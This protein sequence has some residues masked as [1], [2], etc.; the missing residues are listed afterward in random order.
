MSYA[1]KEYAGLM[2]T[3]GFSDALLK[4]HFTLYQGYVTNTNKAL[5][6][7]EKLLKEGRA[8]SPEYA[9]MKR[10]LGWEFNGMRLAGEHGK[11][12]ALDRTANMT[13]AM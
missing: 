2:G 12:F 4:N 13:S 10:R 8:A 7:L 11:G 5:E 9:E 6:I 3:P 1:P